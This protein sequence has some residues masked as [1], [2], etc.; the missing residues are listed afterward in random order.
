MKS[1]LVGLGNPGDQY[2]N[3]RHNVGFW[4]IDQ[5]DACLRDRG[6]VREGHAVPGESP[7]GPSSLVSF[8]D[9][10]DSSTLF[11]LKPGHF[12][13]RS[14]GPTVAVLNALGLDCDSLLVAFDDLDLPVGRLRLRGKG[15]SAGHR[16]VQDIIDQLGR[17]EFARL[18]VGIDRP[19]ASDQVV[20]W[21]LEPFA[22]DAR[23]LVDLSVE[24]ATR[25]SL[26]WW[27]SGL[28]A[29]MNRFNRWRP[30]QDEETTPSRPQE[31]GAD[32]CSSV[33][34]RP[35][36]RSQDRTTPEGV[37]MTERLYEG[38]FL[39]DANESARRWT[40][41][42]TRVESILS[43]NDAKLKYTERWPDQRLAYEIKG[44]RKG[45]YYLTYFTAP[46]GNVQQIRR[47]SELT[48]DILR[49]LV[50]H[51]EGLDQEMEQRRQMAVTRKEDE[52]RRAAERA[53]APVAEESADATAAASD[54]APA[55]E[56]TG[57][58]PAAD[59]PAAEVTADAPAAEATDDAPAVAAD[60]PAENAAP[61]DADADAPKA[62]EGARE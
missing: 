4:V 25:A 47:D 17:A 51:E 56:T 2:A 52:A 35:G 21:V 29:A 3:T 15:S 36:A 42:E 24:A 10:A 46:P 16:G 58:A 45:T 19:A 18:K 54:D 33:E 40:E 13:N 62:E 32:H 14:G 43:K 60:A 50:L 7:A 41:L 27:K 8:V 53:A 57:D 22:T 11:L 26:E 61:A 5:L 39:F 38:M 28:E 23:S 34:G 31:R 37:R 12:M 44:A 9:P 6:L 48:E 20:D 1:L 55:A 30:G 49:V 59:A